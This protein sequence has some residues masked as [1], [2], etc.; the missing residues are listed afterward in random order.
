V[1]ELFSNL[2]SRGP[3]YSPIV[4]VH[5]ILG[6]RAARL[7]LMS[8]GDVQD[9]IITNLSEQLEKSGQPY[10]PSQ[11]I[12]YQWEQDDPKYPEYALRTGIISLTALLPWAKDQ[13]ES[14]LSSVAWF[15]NQKWQK[16]QDTTQ[17]KSEHKGSGGLILFLALAW[18]LS[19][20]SGR[21]AEYRSVCSLS[22]LET[23]P[24][25]LELFSW[26]AGW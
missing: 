6:R 9:Q 15:N 16:H 21:G 1:V 19:G 7:K 10:P 22:R 26:P 24:G 13:L 12:A 20:S 8:Y 17:S 14:T 2:S 5:T 18:L 11:R 25:T 4:K 3:W 23:K